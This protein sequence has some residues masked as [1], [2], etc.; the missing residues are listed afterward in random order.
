MRHFLNLAGI[1]THEFVVRETIAP[2]INDVKNRYRQLVYVEGVRTSKIFKEKGD[3]MLLET[4]NP[5]RALMNFLRVC[6][7]ECETHIFVKR[8]CVNKSKSKQIDRTYTI[9]SYRLLT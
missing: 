5:F 6:A 8:T 9:L 2:H 4:E 3:A 7:K 1:V